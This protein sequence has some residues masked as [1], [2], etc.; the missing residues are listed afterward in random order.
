MISFVLPHP[1]IIY[2]WGKTD[3]FDDEETNQAT[4]GFIGVLPISVCCRPVWDIIKV[5]LN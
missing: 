3:N 4:V 1:V 5:F 2:S